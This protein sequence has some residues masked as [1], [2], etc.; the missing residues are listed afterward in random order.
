M[1]G[2]LESLG[3]GEPFENMMVVMAGVGTD[4]ET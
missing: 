4:N 3:F 2:K 1:C